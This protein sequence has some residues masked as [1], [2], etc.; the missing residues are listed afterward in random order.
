MRFSIIVPIYNVSKYL[1]ECLDSILNQSFKDY[2][3]I[4]VDDGS[5]DES[6]IICDSYAE[7]DP[8]IVVIHKENGGL[9][10][11]RKA[12][13][14]IVRGE[15]VLGVDGDDSIGEKYLEDISQMIDQTGADM[16]AWGFTRTE[17][18]GKKLESSLNEAHVGLYKD[19]EL[20]KIRKTY[21]YDPG[22]DE[23]NLGCLLFNLADKAIKKNIYV[24][25]QLM[26]PDEVVEGEDAVANWLII[27]HISSLYVSDLDR[28]YYRLNPASIMANITN[29]VIERQKALEDFLLQHID[30]PSQI[31]Q[32]QGF[33]FYRIFFLLD[34]AIM[35]GHKNYIKLMKEGQ[36]AKIYDQCMVA[37]I[38][39][40]SFGNS[41]RRFLIKMNWW[42]LLF[43]YHKMRR[44][45]NEK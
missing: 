15:Y 33:S 13:A 17:S 8:R 3:L 19:E 4:L 27:K 26:V 25:N 31:K 21:L 18:N 45:A 2:E 44:K 35:S 30:D 43:I 16:I 5:K 20:E 24:T 39:N 42:N 7:K 38:K 34:R 23:I 14:R 40:I 9:V 6:G 28:Y 32:V 37:E 36:K 10:S 41:L 1:N 29:V 22:R 12:A 11:A